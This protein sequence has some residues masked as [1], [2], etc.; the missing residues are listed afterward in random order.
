MAE[1]AIFRVAKLQRGYGKQSIGRAIRHLDKHLESADI[2]R[3][4]RVDFDKSKIFYD[5][6]RTEIK[7]AIDEHNAVSRKSLRRD[8]SVALEFVFTFSPE[9]ESKINTNDFYKCIRQFFSEEFATCKVLRIDF[10]ASESVNHF[11]VLALPT[12]KDNKLSS[13][14]FLGDRTRMSQ[15]QD[16]FAELCA[17]IGLK[18]GLKR[19]GKDKP[20]HLTLRQYKAKQM[21]EIR[22]LHNIKK[23]VQTELQ[24]ELCR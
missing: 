10:H 19:S 13:R 6:Y 20:H 2:S 12:C 21:D 24:Q 3:P 5:D 14:Q 22:R 7:K 11:H 16:R 8:A 4:E 23:R 1:Y 9:M 18:R 17:G 15:L